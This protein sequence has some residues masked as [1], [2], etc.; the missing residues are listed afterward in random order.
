M[1]FYKNKGFSFGK[2]TKS[3]SQVLSFLGKMVFILKE[4]RK[5]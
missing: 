2:K 4:I 5:K 3:G 1:L